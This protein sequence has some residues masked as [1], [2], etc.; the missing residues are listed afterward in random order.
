MADAPAQSIQKGLWGG[1]GVQLTVT[2]DGA[3][4]EYDCGHGGMD[5]VIAFDTHGRF[6]LSGWH[7]QER[8]GPVREGTVDQKLAARYVGRVRNDQMTLRV[9]LTDSGTTLGPFSLER[10]KRVRLVKCR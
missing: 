7:A 4:V 5:E 3:T 9:E 10:G 8:G 2:A 1:E 6:E